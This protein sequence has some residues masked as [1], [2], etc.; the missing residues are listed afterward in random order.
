MS[1]AYPAFSEINVNSLE[2]KSLLLENISS[3]RNVGKALPLEKLNLEASK[4]PTKRELMQTSI[5]L[6]D[7]G[8]FLG[9]KWPIVVPLVEDSQERSSLRI[10]DWRKPDSQWTSITAGHAL[11]LVS[12][13]L[14]ILNNFEEQPLITFLVKENNSNS[15]RPLLDMPL[16]SYCNLLF[17]AIEPEK[18]DRFPIRRLL[19]RFIALRS[20]I[21]K[22]S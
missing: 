18:S 16:S 17:Q 3:I 4:L 7:I 9:T 12:Q 20:Q 6:R 5:R 15:Y 11:N 22:L 2:S 19:K 10:T 1:Y 13:E 21:S 14:E 8:R